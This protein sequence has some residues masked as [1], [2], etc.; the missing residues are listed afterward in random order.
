MERV[1]KARH[2]LSGEEES[3]LR[4]IKAKERYLR[5]VDALMRRYNNV[6]PVTM[7]IGKGEGEPIYGFTTIHAKPSTPQLSIPSG[8]SEYAINVYA[9]YDR[10]GLWYCK[11]VISQV[12]NN[13]T[14]TSRVEIDRDGD[15]PSSK[16]LRRA[17]KL[18]DSISHLYARSGISQINP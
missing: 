16:Q 10:D 2:H 15:L 8:D 17:T 18:I 14:L 9:T 12:A 7:Q 11:S 4:R 3:V 5:K 1:E 6:E 13:V